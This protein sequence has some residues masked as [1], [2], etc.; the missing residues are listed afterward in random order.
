[1]CGRTACSLDRDCI[2]KAIRKQLANK[3]AKQEQKPSGKKKKNAGATDA[4]EWSSHGTASYYPRFNLAPNQQLPVLLSKSH[5]DEHCDEQDRVLMPMMWGLVPAWHKGDRNEFKMHTI[6]ARS[7]GIGDTKIYRSAIKH[8]R[9]CVVLAEGYFEW[10]KTDGQKQKQPYMIY[11]PQQLDFKKRD[12]TWE[13]LE[14]SE[15]WPRLL[16]IAA[17][18]EYNEHLDMYSVSVLT[19]QASK[20]LAFIHNRM[21]VILDSVEDIDRWLNYKSNAFESVRD[22]LKPCPDLTY[23]EV[24]T[25]VGNVRNNDIECVLPPAKEEGKAK[26]SK[27]QPTMDAFVRKRPVEVKK[28]EHVSPTK[29]E[30]A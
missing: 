26:G 9:R 25:K 23:H 24:H 18:F 16:T 2:A 1:M 13:Q 15:S 7:E 11:F 21:P 6:N 17:L 8:G 20:P 5:L 14:K 3:D 10:K 30:K 4:V 22:L 29:K 27:G 19:T 12:W 28:E